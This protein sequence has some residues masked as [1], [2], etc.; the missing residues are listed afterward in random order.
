ML[1]N[2]AKIWQEQKRLAEQQEL[3]KKKQ[4]EEFLK[5][6]ASECPGNVILIFFTISCSSL[7]FHFILQSCEIDCCVMKCVGASFRC[8]SVHDGRATV[9][10]T[11]YY[12]EKTV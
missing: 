4:E 12:M 10:R 11:V 8:I 5:K 7:I 3:Q 9:S 2:Q 6:A 1:Q